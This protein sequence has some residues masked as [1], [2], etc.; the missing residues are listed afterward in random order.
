[1]AKAKCKCKAAECE[2]CPEWIF[3]F[4]DLVM[5]MM[6]FF[7]ILWVLKPPAGKDGEP[8]PAL[9]FETIGK[10]REAFG[11]VPDP[12]SK[13]PIDVEMLRHMVP[14]RGPSRGGKVSNEKQGKEGTEPEVEMV[15]PSKQVGT[16]TKVLFNP[17][18][19]KL[20][21]ESMQ[22]L[23]AIALLIKGHT[24]IYMIKGH[25]AA[26]DFPE[27]SDESLKMDLSLRRAQAAADYLVTRG[28]DRKT[29]RVQG[30]STY[31]PLVQRAYTSETRSQNRRVEV[32]STA[33]L[34]KDLQDSPKTKGPAPAVE[35]E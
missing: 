22:S 21:P 2:E 5:L 26:D 30:C 16:G 8:A 25:T 27:A 34:V 33:T 14:A 1:M 19:A 29:L 11:Y 31:E 6:G 10:I 32:E 24:N 15:R 4:A 17:G 13:D 18:D 12:N 23:D 35:K 7:V 20:P 3:T 28:V 9:P